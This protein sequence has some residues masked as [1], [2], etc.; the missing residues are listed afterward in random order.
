MELNINLVKGPPSKNKDSSSEEKNLFDIMY[1][2]KGSHSAYKHCRSDNSSL[3]S[4]DNSK[5]DINS[6]S[7]NNDL[8]SMEGLLFCD[9]C[10]SPLYINFL[11]NLDLSFDCNCLLLNNS[12]IEEYINDYMLKHKNKKYI[13]C[14][15]KH[16]K[17]TKFDYYCPDC[18]YD[19][20]PE[21]LNEESKTYS[22]TRKKY[23]A[24]E[25]HILI[26]LDEIIQKFKNIKDNIGNYKNNIKESKIYNKEQKQKIIYI[27]QLINIILNFYPK[28]KC[29]NFYR[30]IENAEIFLEK[31][32]NNFIFGKHENFISLRKITSEKNLEQIKNFSNFVSINIK[33]SQFPI[34]LTIFK[35]KKLPHLKILK[36]VGTNINSI[37][38]LFSCEFPKLEI[39][40]LE[41]NEI[42]NSIID[43]LKKVN[44]PNL[45]YLSLFVNKITNIQIFEVIEKFN[46]LKAFHIGENK[47]DFVNNNKTFY[48]FPET[49]EEFGLTGNFNGEKVEFIEKLGIDNLKTFFF[50]RNKITNLKYLKNIKFKRL[51]KFWS[52]SNELNDIKEI[53][54]INNKD[55]LKYINLRENKIKNFQE[56]LDIISHFPKLEKLILS[57]NE[58]IKDKEV[59]EMMKNIK[60]KY[61]RDLSIKI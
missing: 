24:H 56:L 31:I 6:F 9:K 2:N 8:V 42:D 41:R 1:E 55:S 37:L 39:L 33:Y 4:K 57:D 34:D 12:T 45:F 3:N 59:K 15:Q 14:C 23:K 49:L 40:H 50:S 27:F 21:C 18:D 7:L 10:K 26:K 54:N 17:E 28:Y 25:N 20:C 44:L 16:P 60:E 19:L 29:Y 51:E 5:E 11:D 32:K 46:K 22:N 36:L 58:D 38:P 61:N 53:M 43:L 30:T 47:F 52:I 35:D 13:F 48:K